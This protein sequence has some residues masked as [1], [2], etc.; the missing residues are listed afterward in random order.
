M[1][2]VNNTNV[3]QWDAYTGNKRIEDL[4]FFSVD[5]RNVNKINGVGVCK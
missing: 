5:R 3:Y 4:S 1:K 2:I